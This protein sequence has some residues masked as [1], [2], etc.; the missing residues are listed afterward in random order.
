MKVEGFKVE[1][2][3]ILYYK[4]TNLEKAID[5]LFVEVDRAYREGA[6]IIILSDR[7]VDEYNVPIPSLLA[8]SALQQYLVKTRK[9]THFALIL[10]SGEPREVHHFATLLGYGACAINPYLAHEARPVPRS[11]GDFGRKSRGR[12][13]RP[14]PDGLH[15]P[16]KRPLR[17]QI[18]TMPAG[19]KVL[20]KC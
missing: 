6:D 12:G 9:R 11:L 16:E 14:V 15:E 19:A 10:E 8:V 13:G 5:N 4:N 17:V 1:V 2:I 20:Q 7:G 18:K 3:S